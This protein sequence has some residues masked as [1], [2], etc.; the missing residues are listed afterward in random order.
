MKVVFGFSLIVLSNLALAS[1]NFG[2]ISFHSTINDQEAS[3]LKTDLRYLFT[4]QY[5][6]SDN[7]FLNLTGIK[8]L[9][10]PFVF[11]YLA[12]RVRALVGEDYQM[13]DSTLIQRTDF[14]F[15]QTP[16]PDLAA[17]TDSKTAISETKEKP[18]MTNL[19]SSLYIGGKTAK[20]LLGIR[21]DG[22]KAYATSPRVGILQISE[23][24][25]HPDRLVNQDPKAEVNSISRLA[26]LFH[27][28]R[29]SDGTG[30]STGFIHSKCPE[31]HDFEDQVACDET[32]N[33]A[34]T[35]S[36]LAERMLLQNCEQCS[37]VEKT[38]LEANILDSLSRVLKV[39]QSQD[40]DDLNHLIT[41]YKDT[42]DLY[43]QMHSSASGEHADSILEE[44]SKLNAKITALE[45]K[46]AIAMNSPTS[47]KLILGDA[48]PEGDF[49]DISE[50]TSTRSMKKSLGRRL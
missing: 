15:P 35:V 28:S 45:E 29:H 38:Q 4:K 23:G 13:D 42:L 41:V 14:T 46:L 26:T 7:D 39:T 8:K 27:E 9:Q 40:I 49:R 5:L 34:Y 19:G 11:N 50:K 31:G 47:P 18:V 32:S 10:G 20:T 17:S 44:I 36:A 43:Q 21:L 2:G 12:N 48:K 22:H 6:L 24:L 1:S 37:V 30:I 16:L 3:A 25:F 33:G